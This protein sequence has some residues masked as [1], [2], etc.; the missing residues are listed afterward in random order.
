MRYKYIWAWGRYTGSKDYYIKDQVALAE[1]ENAPENSI[2]K[3]KK[4]VW[5]TVDTL[6]NPDTLRI[7]NQFSLVFT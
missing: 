6:K 2:Y 4:G 7:I 1:S 5:Q 3:D